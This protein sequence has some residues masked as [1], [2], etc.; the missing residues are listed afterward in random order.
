MGSTVQRGHHVRFRKIQWFQSTGDECDS[1]VLAIHIVFVG[2]EDFI[3]GIGNGYAREDDGRALQLCGDDDFSV[4]SVA[5][6]S[7]NHAPGDKIVSGPASDVSIHCDET[8]SDLIGFA[9][10]SVDNIQVGSVGYADGARGSV[11]RAD[12]ERRGRLVTVHD[13]KRVVAESHGGTAVCGIANDQFRLLAQRHILAERQHSLIVLQD[14]AA[15]VRHAHGE[16]SF[17]HIDV[18]SEKVLTAQVG[19]SVILGKRAYEISDSA[20][21]D[22]QIAEIRDGSAAIESNGGLDGNIAL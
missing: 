13:Q 2:D 16:C 10:F 9:Y 1:R 7:V 8:V 21:S 19:I 12:H 6:D 5:P 15:A 3:N 4:C 11:R 14:Y 18:A 22:G 17:E 20:G